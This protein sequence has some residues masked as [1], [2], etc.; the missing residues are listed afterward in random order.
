M[1]KYMRALP[2]GSQMAWVGL[3]CGRTC[4]T[5]TA[6][7]PALCS[8]EPL[9]GKQRAAVTSATIWHCFD[10]AAQSAKQNQEIDDW[11]PSIRCSKSWPAPSSREWI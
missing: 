2:V 8:C 5:A 11:W 4:R 1:G 10:W 7:W 9:E 6:P 3:T